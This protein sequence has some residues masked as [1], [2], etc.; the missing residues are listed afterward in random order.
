[1]GEGKGGHGR[2][3]VIC[4]IP[5]NKPVTRRRLTGDGMGGDGRGPNST[6]ACACAS[7]CAGA[8]AKS[9]YQG[10]RRVGTCSGACTRPLL[11]HRYVAPFPIRCPSPFQFFVLNLSRPPPLLLLLL[12][13]PPLPPPHS[14]PQVILNDLWKAPTDPLGL[15][16]GG[17]SG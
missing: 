16:V 15:Q 1:M 12:L 8:A 17:G 11:P 5:S 4:T 3:G 14:I 10:Q 7:V 2:G 9:R 6:C 13:V